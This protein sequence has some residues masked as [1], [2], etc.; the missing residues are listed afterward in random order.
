M[1]KRISLI[2]VIFAAFLFLASCASYNITRDIPLKE[3]ISSAAVLVRLSETSRISHDEYITN[4]KTME[5]GL[6]SVSKIVYLPSDG[7]LALYHTTGDRFY[8]EAANSRFLKYKTLGT[9]RVFT[10][11]NEAR[12][13]SFLSDSG[14]DTLIIYEIG[15]SYS[16]SLKAMKFDSVITVLDTN[17]EVVYL[18]HQKSYIGDAEYDADAVRGEFMD[19]LTSRWIETVKELGLSSDE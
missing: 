7:A 14:V 11:A 5:K 8:Q 13:K 1:K 19:N 12:L 17:L 18:D 16:A 15:G 9:I 4:F 3:K 2:V 10:A 6:E